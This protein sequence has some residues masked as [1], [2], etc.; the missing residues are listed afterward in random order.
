MFGKKSQMKILVSIIKYTVVIIVAA[1][2][3]SCNSQEKNEI[4]TS[5]AQNN[6]ESLPIAR[7]E[8]IGEYVIET[9]EDSK[10]NLWFGTLTKGVAKYDG[11]TLKYFTTEDGLAENAITSIVEGANGNLWFGTHLG[12]SQY[13]G[14]TFTNF[15][16]EDGLCHNRISNLLIDSKGDFWIGTWGGVCTF[17]GKE[18]TSLEIPKP[19]IETKPNKDTKNWITTII[20]DSK[21]AIWIGRDGYGA[22]KYDG[23]AFVH[24]LKKDGLYSNNVHKIIEDKEGNIWFGTRV[25]EKDHPD[26]NKR[27]GKGGITKY[28]G[29]SF[30][31]YPEIEGINDNDVY[32]IYMDNAEN[33]WIGTIRNGVYK[34]DG[35]EFENYDIPKAIVSIL[36]DTKGNFWFG[37]AGG[38]FR[39]NSTGVVNVTTNGPW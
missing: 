12:L 17:N 18:F 31:H 6:N 28:D 34:F 20:E 27:F 21:G 35:K 11:K 32:E 26:S 36:E 38:L 23:K 30:V 9:F 39:I 29:T 1:I 2:T 4:P 13:D 14:D 24:F 22:C 7:T 15:T 16:T 25:A 8:Q 19:A 10:G 37:C 33:L 5:E 3:T